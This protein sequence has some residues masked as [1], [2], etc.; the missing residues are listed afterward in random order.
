MEGFAFLILGLIGAILGTILVL[1]YKF[2]HVEEDIRIQELTKM[3]PGY[4]CGICGYP[5]CNGF[6]E[7][8]LDERTT[9]LTVCKPGKKA[10]HFEPI[11]AY[12]ETIDKK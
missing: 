6:A 3:L 11:M 8:I 12:L 2:L 7:K 5:G 9:D 1:S 10:E 4:N